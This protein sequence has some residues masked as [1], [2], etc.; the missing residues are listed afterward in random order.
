MKKIATSLLI[1]CGFC[2]RVAML[3]YTQV[4]KVTSVSRGL[5]KK[6]MSKF[7]YKEMM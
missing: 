3:F 4:A 2:I 1:L 6:R 7:P 5:P